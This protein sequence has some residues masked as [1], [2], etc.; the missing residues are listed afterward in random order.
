MLKRIA[1]TGPESTGKSSLAEALAKQYCTVWVPEYAR[2]YI[3]DLKRD[4]TQDDILIIARQQFIQEEAAAKQ[5]NE[6]LFLDTEFLVT[7]IWSEVKYKNCD[8][9]IVKQYRE[10][11]YD[12][13]L[14]CNIDLPWEADP[15]REHPH[16]RQYLF[17]L[18]YNDLLSNGLP[19]GVVSGMGDERLKNA[20]TF[21]ETIR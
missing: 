12:F 21:I 10:H 16:L 2:E 13:Y 19:F 9:W 17:D 5:A 7:K 3:G 1:I 6:F 8:P 20:V 18:Y 4:Y 15:Q 14:L 11:K